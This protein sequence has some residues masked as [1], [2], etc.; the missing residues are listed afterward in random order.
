MNLSAEIDGGLL[1]LDRA[2]S[3]SKSY[4]FALLIASAVWPHGL[5]CAASS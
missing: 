1:N 5:D 4:Q 3:Q 2:Y